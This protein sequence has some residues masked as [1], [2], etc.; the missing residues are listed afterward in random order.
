MSAEGGT[1]VVVPAPPQ[2]RYP[3]GCSLEPAPFA[4]DFLVNW[5][6]DVQVNG[7]NHEGVVVLEFLR[8]LLRGPA[9]YGVSPQAAQLAKDRF[10]E[11]AAPLLEQEGGR[12][13]WLERE[14]ER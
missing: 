3:G 14:F 2:P 12:R 13:A 4:L 7:V 1:P 10:L 9:Q 11:L 8:T 5:R 6:A